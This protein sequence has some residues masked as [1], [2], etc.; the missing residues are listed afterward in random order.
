MNIKY[1]SSLKV[2]FLLNLLYDGQYSKKEIIEEFTKNNINIKKTSINNYIEKLKSNDIPIIIKKIKNTNYY[3]LDKNQIIYLKQNETD[4]A[5]DVK[6]ILIAQKNK[7]LIKKAMQIFYKY[8]LHIEDKNTKLELVNF[9]YYSKINWHLVKQLEYHCKNKNIIMLDYI[10]PNGKNKYLII[11]ADTIKIGDWSNRLY[12]SGILKGD[13]K[14]SQLPVDKIFMVKK[15]LKENIR[16]SLKVDVLEYKISK[17]E[18]EKT[19]LDEKEGL[20]KIENNIVTIKRPLDDIFFTVQHLIHFC[21]D[22]Y[23]VSD[24]KIRNYIKEK[25]Y[26]LKDMYENKIEN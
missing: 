21:P 10:L 18:F 22:L 1:T 16:I 23:Y 7:Y 11:H 26:T 3:S 12:L 24:E 14:L 6:K 13:N 4:A 2:L 25:L 9:D 5:Q 19:G 8:A 15:I 20:T 17:K